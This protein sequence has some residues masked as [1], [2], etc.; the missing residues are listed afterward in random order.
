[1]AMIKCPDCGKDVSDKAKACPE[2]GC[3]IDA[4]VCPKCGSANLTKI[5]K[6]SKVASAAVLPF[7]LSVKKIANTY[8]CNNCKHKF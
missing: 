8:Q 2:C 3:P 5:S 6:S 7:W 4:P 1:M